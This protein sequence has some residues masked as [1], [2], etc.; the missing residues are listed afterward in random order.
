MRAVSFGLM[1]TLSLLATTFAATPP[2]I[3][4]IKVITTGRV[5]ISKRQDGVNLVQIRFDE[6]T[7]KS[8]VKEY[9]ITTPYEINVNGAL[10]KKKHGASTSFE[11]LSKAQLEQRFPGLEKKPSKAG[12][13]LY[14]CQ[15]TNSGGVE[16]CLNPVGC[17]YP[18]YC[19]LTSSPGN[20]YCGC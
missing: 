6:S 2:D 14:A 19:H 4:D 8:I 9:M 3:T 1:V 11:A 7:E 16:Q 18:Q 15:Y 12:S 20:H 10:I 5:T 13:K 17:T